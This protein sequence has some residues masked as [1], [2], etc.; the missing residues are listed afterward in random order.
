MSKILIVDDEIEIL[1]PLEEMLKEEGFEVR[2][3]TNSLKALDFLRTQS[4]D[5]AIFDIKMPELNGV[6]DFSLAHYALHVCNSFVKYEMRVSLKKVLRNTVGLF[7][8]TLVILLRSTMF[9][10]TKTAS[11]EQP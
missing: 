2:A 8:T 7:P 4:V 9:P 1:N 3:F 10:Q 6:E 5:L 11:T